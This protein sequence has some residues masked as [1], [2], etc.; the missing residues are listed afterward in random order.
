LLADILDGAI[1][2][3]M[4]VDGELG[5]QLDS[6]ADVVSFGALPAV[7]MY[8]IATPIIG[9]GF[10]TLFLCAI[11][12]VSA[13]LRLARFNIDIRPREYF[14]GLATPS[15]A[16]MVAALGWSVLIRKDFDD[17][18]ELLKYIVW[19]LPIFLAVMYQV[20]LKLP[21]LKSPRAGIYTL[22]VIAV[23]TIAGMF[24]LGPIAIACGIAL[25]VILG[26]INTV[27]NWY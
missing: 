8:H 18:T 1:A 20:A 9:A 12:A 25:Y 27:L 24:V 14:W 19:V 21:G 10:I 26:L 7:I 4:G 3:K 2:R 13:G 16:I 15:G 6:L 5:I 22:V 11:I 17:Q 23:L